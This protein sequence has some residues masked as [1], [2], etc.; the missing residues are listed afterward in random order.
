MLRRLVVSP[1][2]H[3]PETL[4]PY[5]LPLIIVVIGLE[6]TNTNTEVGAGFEMYDVY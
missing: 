4:V 5:I 1:S 6:K 3:Q 2:S